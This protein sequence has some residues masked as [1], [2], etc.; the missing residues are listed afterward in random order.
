[1]NNVKVSYSFRITCLPSS[2]STTKD[3]QPVSHD[4][5]NKNNL[6]TSETFHS[7]HLNCCAS[8]KQPYREQL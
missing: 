4:I 2:N 6:T 1:M 8:L 5:I 3:T 7:P